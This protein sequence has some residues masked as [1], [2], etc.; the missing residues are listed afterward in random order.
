MNYYFY[1]GTNPEYIRIMRDKMKLQPSLK[2]RQKITRKVEAMSRI[3][4]YCRSEIGTSYLTQ[5]L[6]NETNAVFYIEDEKQTTL[7]VIVFKIDEGINNAF[8][9][10]PPNI[11]VDAF[12]TPFSGGNGRKLMNMVIQFGKKIGTESIYLSAAY[13]AVAFYQKMGFKLEQY[14][15]REYKKIKDFNVRPSARAS[16]RNT[17][18]TFEQTV[19]QD[20]THNGVRIPPG[21]DGLPYLSMEYR[22]D[23]NRSQSKSRRSTLSQRSATVFNSRLVTRRS[24]KYKSF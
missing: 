18:F 19:A 16:R 5:E 14:D 17:S 7:G 24:R 21:M 3:Q 12:C 1:K 11:V 8:F 13:N 22:Y 6:N 20:A 4:D 15:A 9:S 10:T 23:R 2:T